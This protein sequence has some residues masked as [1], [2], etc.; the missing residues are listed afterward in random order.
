MS[1]TTDFG[2]KKITLIGTAHVSMQSINEV[3]EAIAELSPDCVAIEL[4]EKRCAALLEPEKYRS[5][6]IIAVLKRKEGFLLLAN[7]MLA[8]FQRRMGSPLGVK[9]GDE[10]LA[11]LQAAKAQNIPT[12]L[13]DRPIASTLRR[14]WAKNSFFGKI[15]LLSALL[16]S[17]FDNETVS[18]EQIENL[19]NK[20]EMDS[21]MAELSEYLPAVKE[22]LINER[23]FYLAAKIWNASGKNIVAV[24]GAGHKK[25]VLEHLQKMS[26]GEE[27]TDT[28][29]I[30]NPP[31][32]NG[33]SKIAG[34]IIP[35]FI[36]ALIITGFV[37]GGMQA[38]KKMIGSWVLWN[39]AFAALGAAIA[40]GHPLA[41]LASA[42]AAPLTS[43]TP[44]VGVGI[45]SGI[46]QA[47][48]KKPTVAD[49]ENIQK[50]AGQFSKWYK[51]RVLRVLLV[52]F[53]SSLGSS[54]GTFVGGANII[55]MLSDF[56]S[57]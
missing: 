43:L 26:R 2:E 40:L 19:K 11:A 16:A 47:L 27:S 7:L 33:F 41:I 25:G 48:A 21:M 23:D 14:A 13:A 49:M 36:V 12:V 54:V 42:L 55:K 29:A 38:G 9:P 53:F 20:N 34:Y 35:A 44:V 5:L 32:K 57:K 30:E 51:N 18:S 46:V 6:D 50:D 1:E 37:A 10:M 15:K 22:V 39:A 4:D 28:S 56:F 17:C 8:S 24:I 45:V 31:K 3:C 52:F